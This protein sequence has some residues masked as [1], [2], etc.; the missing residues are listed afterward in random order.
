MLLHLKSISFEIEGPER[1]RHALLMSSF[2]RF[3]DLPL[4]VCR[5]ATIC[6]KSEQLCNCGKLRETGKVKL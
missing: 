4:P 3:I 1:R 2:L 5:D 6:E